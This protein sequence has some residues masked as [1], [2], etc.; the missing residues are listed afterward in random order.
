MTKVN[1]VVISH[2]KKI[3]DG[4]A[5]LVSQVKKP[6]VHIFTAGGTDDGNIGTSVEKI[7]KAI[8]QAYSKA[9]VL[10]FYDLG[11][12][13][14]NAEV[15]AEMFSCGLV[16]TADAPLVEGAYIATVESGLG[17]SLLEVKQAVEVTTRRLKTSE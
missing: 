11:S 1:I 14:M 8:N 6:D 16:E 7:T 4:I 9:G 17:K 5:D 3:V 15:A 2:S 12:A 13:S 10:L